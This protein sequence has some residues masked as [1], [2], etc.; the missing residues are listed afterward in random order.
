L[1]LLIVVMNR[2][3]QLRGVRGLESYMTHKYSLDEDQLQDFTLLLESKLSVQEWVR[4]HYSRL[5]KR[6]VELKP[7][8]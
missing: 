6:E 2:E 4:M 3:L 1:Q 8:I 7:A 5:K